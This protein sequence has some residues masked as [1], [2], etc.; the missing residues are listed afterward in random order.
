MAR[1]NVTMLGVL[2]TIA[3]LA[4]LGYISYKDEERSRQ[5][6]A[7]GRKYGIKPKD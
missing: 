5:D 1:Y 2:F 7:N 6:I 3:L 4:L